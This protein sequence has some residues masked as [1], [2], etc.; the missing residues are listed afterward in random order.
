MTDNTYGKTP[1]RRRTSK[2]E[3]RRERQEQD[4]KDFEEKN[5][6]KSIVGRTPGQRRLLRALNEEMGVFADGPAGSGK[7]FLSVA[8]GA[9]RLALG[10][11][12][13]LVVAR[14]TVDA[15]ENLGFL[16]GDLH[17]KLAHW[18]VPIFESLD[19]QVGAHKRR[20]WLAEGKLEVVA[21][22][23]I[24][25]RT[26]DEAFVVL[27]EAQNTTPFQM[28]TFL[29][30]MGQ[31]TRYSVAG[32]PT[33]QLAI[34]GVSGMAV[35][36]QLIEQRNLPVAVVKLTHDDIVRSAQAKM[37]AEAFYSTHTTKE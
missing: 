23:H 10:E 11:I 30:R 17:S 13:K 20:T 2:A 32:D 4:R 7:T 3:A 18:M 1:N 15:D 12:K 34:K 29:T 21:F 19:K 36:L 16:P 37:W 28:E 14:P 26:F 33:A 22:Q 5:A 24:Q 8:T 25:G 9:R 31:N 27:D 35:A 6:F